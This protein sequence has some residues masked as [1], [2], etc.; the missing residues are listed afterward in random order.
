MSLEKTLLD[1]H[2]P[3]VVFPFAWVF[4]VGFLNQESGHVCSALVAVLDGDLAEEIHLQ[5]MGELCRGDLESEAHLIKGFGWDNGGGWHATKA[6]LLGECPVR[7]RVDVHLLLQEFW[8]Q[9]M[10]VR[11]VAESVECFVGVLDCQFD[12]CRIVSAGGMDGRVQMRAVSR[13]L[14]RR[15][16]QELSNAQARRKLCGSDLWEGERI[17]FSSCFLQLIVLVMPPSIGRRIT[18]ERVS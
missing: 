8:V 15:K 9:D 5:D 17:G 6:L 10:I 18:D 14:V 1:E 16:N 7:I 11:R 3:P 4:G 13:A 12:N 2:A